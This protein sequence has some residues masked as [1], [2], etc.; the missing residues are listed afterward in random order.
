MPRIPMPKMIDFGTRIFEAAGAPHEVAQHV[1]A[2]LVK[3]DL[4]GVYSHG[5]GLLPGYVSRL[6]EGVIATHAQ[7]TIVKEN[8]WTALVDGH[9][10]FG[11]IVATYAMQ[12]AMDKARANGIA[13]V[14]VLHSNHIGRI[15]EYVETA[16]NAGL[17]GLAMVNAT[18]PIVTPYNGI[19]HI[20]GTNPI[21]FAVPVPNGRPM[22]LDFATSSVAGNKVRVAVNK[23]IKIP[24]GW[25]LDNEGAQTDDPRDLSNGGYLLPVAAHKGYGLSLMV[26]IFAGLL[27]GTGSALH[28]PARHYN[29]CFFMVLSPDTF[30]PSEE[31]LGD[32]RRLADELR[33]TPPRPLP[34]ST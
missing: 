23:G 24:K 8:T 17:I 9:E 21:A 26:E 10:N 7:P 25:I 4:Y 19:G 34:G 28:A 33:A 5:I 13:I 32:V 6:S 14:S 12:V 22:L 1:S 2:S 16:A 27:S 20:F 3:S 18:H 15:G 11:Q 30:R 29:G 31:F